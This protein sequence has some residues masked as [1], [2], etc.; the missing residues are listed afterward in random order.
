MELYLDTGN[1][2]EIREIA[3][4]G[5]L[6]GVTTNP[7]LLSREKGDYKEILKEI[8]NIV[9]GPV[10]GEV[11][12]MDAESMVKEAQ[13]LAKISEHIVIKVPLT[14][15]GIKAIS[16][17]SKMGIKTN[18]TLVFS[19]NQ[20]LLAARAGADYVSPFVGRMEDIGHKAESFVK[21]IIT[22]FKNYNFKT[23]IIFASVRH[24]KHV[25]Q[26]ALWGVDI[27]TIPYNVFKKLPSHP[28]TDIG[29]KKFL[30]DWEKR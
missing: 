13:E 19:P 24:P 20:A 8:C 25:L 10:S 3:S 30:E 17:L 6:S 21:D 29:L 22:I 18:A 14:V 16:Q 2:D 27:A 28:M 23:K 12:S 11:I 4:W 7:T 9:K 15:E 26:A 5:I 1:I